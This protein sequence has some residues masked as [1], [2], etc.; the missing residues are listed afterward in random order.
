MDQ[1]SI[2]TAKGN[3]VYSW[4]EAKNL[5]DEINFPVIIRPSFTLGGTGG[6]V[7]YNFEEFQGLVENGISSSPI[8]EI[9]IEESLIGW[10]E[11]ELEVVRDKSDTVSY[12]HLT[13]PTKRIV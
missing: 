7:A 12:T 3:F 8:N 4:E 6:S 5:L 13:L 11:Y 1:V 2:D 10:K 9:L